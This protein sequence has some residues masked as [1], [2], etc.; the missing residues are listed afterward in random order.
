ML[1]GIGKY[2]FLKQTVRLKIGQYHDEKLVVLMFSILS[3][4]VSKISALS[5][6]DHA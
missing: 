2:T 5:A 3:A 6:E 1:I 4:R